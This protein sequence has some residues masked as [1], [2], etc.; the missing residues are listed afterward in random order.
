[1][2]DLSAAKS[3]RESGAASGQEP[4][5]H[6]SCIKHAISSAEARLAKLHRARHAIC[7]EDPA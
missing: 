4:W 3:H 5:P 6:L 7:L 2:I 1:M